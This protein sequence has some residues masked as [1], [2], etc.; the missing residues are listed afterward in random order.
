MT[1]TT[2]ELRLQRLEAKS[3]ADKTAILDAFRQLDELKDRVDRHYARI[4]ALEGDPI[5][6]RDTIRRA[7]REPMEQPAPEVAPDHE[8]IMAWDRH[9]RSDIGDRLRAVYDLGHEHGAAAAHCPHIRTSDEGTSYCALAEQTATAKPTSNDRQIRSLSDAL[10]AAECALADIA[11][12]EPEPGHGPSSS[13]W[14]ERRCADALAIIRP[15]MRRYGIHAS[16]PVAACPP[17]VGGLVETVARSIG[18][19]GHPVNWRPEARRAVRQVAEWL[20]FRGQP[21]AQWLRDE[22]EAG[23]G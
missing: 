16:G 2:L 14:G 1:D 23:R 6:Q 10:R 19:D 13:E 5:Q 17:P 20:A 21:C 18:Q 12:R 7:I 3:E 15:V 22:L 8:L 11:E 4:R 9:M